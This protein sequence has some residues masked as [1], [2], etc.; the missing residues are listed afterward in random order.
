MEEGIWSSGFPFTEGELSE[1]AGRHSEILT[2]SLRL[3]SSAQK[4][5]GTVR[6]FLAPRLH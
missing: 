4:G 1:I 2:V 6:A 3:R 5:I